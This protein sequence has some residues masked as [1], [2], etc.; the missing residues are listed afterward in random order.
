MVVNKLEKS[1]EG[2]GDPVASWPS[3]SDPGRQRD[4]IGA[5][6]AD[7]RVAEEAREMDLPPLSSVAQ[8]HFHRLILSAFPC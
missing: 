5:R 4:E 7:R 2:G 1:W 8:S 6:G 3:I